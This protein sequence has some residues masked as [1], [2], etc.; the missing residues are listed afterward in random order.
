MIKSRGS[1]TVILWSI[2][3]NIVNIANLGDWGYI[4]F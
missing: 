1:A 3:S 4:L 2:N